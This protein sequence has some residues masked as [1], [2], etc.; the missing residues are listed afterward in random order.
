LPGMWNSGWVYSVREGVGGGSR[1]VVVT[2]KVTGNIRQRAGN[3]QEGPV[4]VWVVSGLVRI[5]ERASW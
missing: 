2:V 5:P 3:G 4:R 1:V